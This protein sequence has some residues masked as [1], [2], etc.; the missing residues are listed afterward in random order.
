[1]DSQWII[2]GFV[3]FVVGDFSFSIAAYLVIQDIGGEYE[4]EIFR[5]DWIELTLKSVF[6]T[7]FTNKYF[8]QNWAAK[9]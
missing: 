6:K 5:R 3:C 1:M 9:I 7:I 2:V 8:S 4:W